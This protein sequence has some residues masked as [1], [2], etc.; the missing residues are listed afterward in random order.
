MAPRRYFGSIAVRCISALRR[1]F[2]NRRDCGELEN[3]EE[4]GTGKGKRT[5]MLTE[6]VFRLRSAGLRKRAI[7]L[8]VALFVFYAFT[9][10]RAQEV[11]DKMVVTVNV[12]AQS[13]CG[14]RCLITYSDLLW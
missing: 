6:R 11:I 3:W 1:H 9:H 4:R 2:K 13:N 10:C 5:A 7:L 14:A 8:P 12:G